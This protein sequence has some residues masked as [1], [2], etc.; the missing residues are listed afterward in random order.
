M[1]P[2][3]R[4]AKLMME[5][6]KAGA[7]FKEFGALRGNFATELSIVRDR[8][9][10]GA[11]TKEPLRK[12]YAEYQDVLEV[13]SYAAKVW[14][15]EIRRDQCMGPIQGSDWDKDLLAGNHRKGM[16][17]LEASNAW[18]ERFKDCFAQ[19]WRLSDLRR[20]EAG[21]LKTDCPDRSSEC[22]FKK[23]ETKLMNAEALLLKH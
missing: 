13:Y 2:T 11:S 17:E 21:S 16:L 5:R 1:Q 19:Y 15:D 18:D 6:L 12:Y 20:Q 4:S 10:T 3:Y 7:D 8:M 22:V 9:S 14:E 23:A